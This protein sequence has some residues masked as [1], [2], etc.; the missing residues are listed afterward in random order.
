MAQI[1]LN[2]S[3][4]ASSGSLLL[5]TNGTTTQATVDTSGNLGLGVTPSAWTSIKALQVVNASFGGL[6]GGNYS[7]SNAYYDGTNWKYITSNYATLYQQSG[8]AGDGVH[9]WNIAASGTAGNTISF[10][11]AMTLDASG[12]LAL[13][14]TSAMG[15]TSNRTVFTVNGTNDSLI[16]MGV[17][18]TR[19]ATFYHDGTNMAVGN[20]ASGYLGF[21]TNGSERARIDSS[22]NWLVNTTSTFASSKAT[23]KGAGNTL[24]VWEQ[25]GS[26]AAALICR[27]DIT[28]GRLTTYNYNGSDVGTVTTNGTSTSY[29]TSSDYRLKEN[30]QPMTGA[31]AKVAALKPCTYKWKADGSDGE[32]FIA[33]ELAEVVPQCVTGEKDA[34]DADGNP[35]Y[36]GIDTSF[37]VATLVAAI[38]EQ[39]AIITQ[40]QADVAALKGQA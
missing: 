34:V 19:K 29:N 21:S 1:T 25:N 30:I 40:L 26:S 8:N 7:A 35:Q 28:S 36:Q 11:Q 38:K 3:G 13:G 37:L 4:V 9:K 2:S 32:G 24:T 5:Q 22:G 10:T 6:G 39:Q 31:L 18:G 33:H 17:G 27:V 16:T 12:N 14:T 15:T 20:D 23:I